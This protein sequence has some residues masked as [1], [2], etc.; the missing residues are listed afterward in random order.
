MD[1]GK[2]LILDEDD[3]LDRASN[4][5]EAGEPAKRRMSGAD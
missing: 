1:S 3:C 2:S 4:L 5:E